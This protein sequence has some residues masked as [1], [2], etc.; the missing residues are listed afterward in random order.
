MKNIYITGILS[1]LLSVTAIIDCEA[2]EMQRRKGPVQF[3][4]AA[5]Q[6]ARA[7]PADSAEFSVQIKGKRNTVT[8]NG[9]VLPAAPDTAD[10]QN[11]IS[12][13]GEGNSITLI[14]TEQQSEVKI[15]Q[16][17]NNNK[18]SISQQ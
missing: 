3:K 8:V 14:Q 4:T 13:D 12:V 18:I 7:S 5:N 11:K 15:S 17:G 9:K 2:Y 6:P 16:K 1:V 10:T